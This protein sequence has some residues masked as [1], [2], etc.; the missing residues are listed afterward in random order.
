M[1]NLTHIEVPLE[2]RADLC[3]ALIEGGLMDTPSPAATVEDWLLAAASLDYWRIAVPCAGAGSKAALLTKLADTLQFPDYFGMNL[4]ALYDCLTD[5]LLAHQK[6]AKK[7]A[8][9][10][11]NDTGTLPREAL[12]AVVD[13]LLDAAEFMQ[14][15][16]QRL[17][18]VLR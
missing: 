14:T 9:L 5:Q 3:A 8:V 4:D 10:I 16:G 15:K 17:C 13:T 11:L 1:N 7:G 2:P 6:T 18:L 12:N